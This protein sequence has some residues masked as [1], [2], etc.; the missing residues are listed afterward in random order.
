LR[1]CGKELNTFSGD[2]LRDKNKNKKTKRKRNQKE[3]HTKETVD[4]VFYKKQIKIHLIV[5]NESMVLKFFK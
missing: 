1:F 5:W 4:F 3:N 2:T